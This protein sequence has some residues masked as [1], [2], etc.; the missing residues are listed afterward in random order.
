MSTNE[1]DPVPCHSGCSEKIVPI[2]TLSLIFCALIVP[3][4]ASL[5]LAWDSVSPQSETISDYLLQHFVGFPGVYFDS[6]SATLNERAEEN[7]KPVVHYLTSHPD[8]RVSLQGHV[9]DH[10]SQ[11]YGLVLSERRAETVKRYLVEHKVTN[12]IDTR[13]YG[14]RRPFCMERT[15]ACRR[16]NNRVRILVTEFQ[17]TA[18]PMPVAM[19]PEPLDSAS[20]TPKMVPPFEFPTVY[21]KRNSSELDT[22]ARTSLAELAGHLKTHSVLQIRLTGRADERHTQA[23]GITLSTK[24][25]EAVKQYLQKQGVGNAIQIEAV[26]QEKPMCFEHIDACFRISN[27]V[28][29]VLSE[30][31]GGK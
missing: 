13:G 30:K 20:R 5:S 17:R 3:I 27:Q 23:E 10:Y 11:T 16:N 31:Q 14:N 15:E 28:Q 26:G 9:D 21:F 25:A 1:D 19:S 18:K 29:V 4:E 6:G 7:L 2:A 8:G 24:R 12:H 22:Q